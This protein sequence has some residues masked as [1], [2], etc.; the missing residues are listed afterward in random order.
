ML[1]WKQSG[2]D[3]IA[4]SKGHFY[5]VRYLGPRTWLLRVDAIFVG[6]YRS[7]VTAKEEAEK[8]EQ[9]RPNPVKD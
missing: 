5:R 8:I 7:D 2:K 4:Q 1:E 9:S 6:R 3:C